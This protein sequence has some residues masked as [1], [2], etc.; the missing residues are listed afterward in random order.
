MTKGNDGTGDTPLRDEWRTPKWLVDSL[1]KQYDIKVDCCADEHNAIAPFWFSKLRPFE[2]R[3]EF[4]SDTAWMNPPFSLAFKMI[5][6]F[7]KVVKKG[8]MIYRCDNIETN[9][10]QLIANN[11]DWIFVFNRRIQYEGE[12]GKG[13]RFGSALAGKNIPP[14]TNLPGYILWCKK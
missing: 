14:P 13:A 1:K 10:W 9:A 5:S 6:T 12:E 11:A 3:I 7:F 8:V 4:I 2:N